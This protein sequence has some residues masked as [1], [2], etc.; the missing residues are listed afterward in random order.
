MNSPETII[1]PWTG[2]VNRRFGVIDFC[3]KSGKN[4]VGLGGDW[5]IEIFTEKWKA[6]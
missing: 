1:L 3:G 5:R 2:A 6:R 4:R